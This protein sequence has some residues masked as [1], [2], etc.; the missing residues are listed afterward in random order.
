MKKRNLKNIFS[1]FAVVAVTAGIACAVPL[2]GC[3]KSSA[4]SDN[5]SAENGKITVIDTAVGQTYSRASDRA[6]IWVGPDAT[7]GDTINCDG[8]FEKPYH[9]NTI[10][11]TS[12]EEDA[13]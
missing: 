10:L 7:S 5:G 4:P 6:P 1:A 3:G 2:A 11:H 13:F 8:S 12:A 9:I